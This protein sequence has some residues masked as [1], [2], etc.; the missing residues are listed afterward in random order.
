MVTPPDCRPRGDLTTNSGAKMNRG[1]TGRRW[2]ETFRHVLNHRGFQWRWPPGPGDR[3][4][5]RDDRRGGQCRQR[6]C[7]LRGTNGPGH[8]REP[9]VERE[10]PGIGEPCGKWRFFWFA[11]AAG[12]FNHDGFCDLAIGISGKNVGT[13]A[14]AGAVQILYGSAAGLTTTAPKSGIRVSPEWLGAPEA[15]DHFGYLWPRG[16]LT[17]T[18]SWTWP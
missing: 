4:A 3:R 9:S 18:V 10:Q 15:D 2:P 7:H 5:L 1:L 16:T 6:P 8:R 17:G 13:G 11:L 14:G 12:D